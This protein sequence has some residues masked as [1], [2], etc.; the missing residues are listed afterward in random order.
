MDSDFCPYCQDGVGDEG[1]DSGG[2]ARMAR[3]EA[4]RERTEG[5]AIV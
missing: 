5:R 4:R 3:T 2:Q 1:K